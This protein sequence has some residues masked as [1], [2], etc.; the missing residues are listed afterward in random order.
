MGKSKR[1]NRDKNPGDSSSSNPTP[2]DQIQNQIHGDDVDSRVT[3]QVNNSTH[4]GNGPISSMGHTGNGTIFNSGNQNRPVGSSKSGNSG[5][6]S[7]SP[8]SQNAPNGPGPSNNSNSAAS[9]STRNI[10]LNSPRAPPT[11]RNGPGLITSLKNIFTGATIDPISNPYAAAFQ[12]YAIPVLGV[13]IA[14]A[15]IQYTFG[16]NVEIH[17]SWENWGASNVNRV[18]NGTNIGSSTVNSKIHRFPTDINSRVNDNRSSSAVNFKDGGWYQ[19]IS[20]SVK[21]LPLP[22]IPILSNWIEN[23]LPL[24][25]DGSRSSTYSSSSGSSTYSS[26]KNNNNQNSPLSDSAKISTASKNIFNHHKSLVNKTWIPSEGDPIWYFHTEFRDYEEWTLRSRIAILDESHGVFRPR[27][28]LSEGWM[29]G[30]IVKKLSEEDAA[31]WRYNTISK[32]GQYE[33]GVEQGRYNDPNTVTSSNYP[34]GS[35]DIASDNSNSNYPY[36][37]LPSDIASDNSN[38]AGNSN[39]KS[40]RNKNKKFKH[41]LKVEDEIYLVE[42]T[43]HHWADARGA[44]TGKEKGGSISKKTGKP[45]GVGNVNHI[46]MKNVTMSHILYRK[47]ESRPFSKLGSNLN[48]KK[49]VVDS[50]GRVTDRSYSSEIANDGSNGKDPTIKAGTSVVNNNSPAKL[51]NQIASKVALENHEQYNIENILQPP[52]LPT[53]EDEPYPEISII[54]IRFGKRDVPVSSPE[55]LLPTNPEYLYNFLDTGIRPLVGN[56][57]DLWTIFLETGQDCEDLARVLPLL[58]GR[59]S[60]A[61]NPKLVNGLGGNLGRDGNINNMRKVGKHPAVSRANHVGAAI[62]MH[63]TGWDLRTWG[64]P[65]EK[66]INN[67]WSAGYLEF[68][69]M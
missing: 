20:E 52:K 14:I 53:N 54:S 10:K 45:R 1:T 55:Q 44:F 7:G 66:Q 64:A 21:D 35:L 61:K 40:N 16:P 32:R 63:P 26:L 17:L 47:L 30:R 42:S 31:N 58:M 6:N 12:T 65:F 67:D 27:I 4:R 22:K 8:P 36:G 2:R 46:M 48:S 60:S 57:Y 56:R 49:F 37:S 25:N 18:V 50:N 51:Q 3:T 69:G 11:L 41:N 19:S 23:G 43:W 28:G 9:G 62:F 34:Y 59:T 68:W 5:A 39:E 38:I 33:F 24:S 13:A 15:V 29:P